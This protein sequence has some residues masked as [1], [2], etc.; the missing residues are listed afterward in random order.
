MDHN[1]TWRKLI[2]GFMHDLVAKRKPAQEDT[3]SRFPSSKPTLE[4]ERETDVR[5]PEVQ[6]RQ[7]SRDHARGARRA[8]RRRRTAARPETRVGAAEC[9]EIADVAPHA[10]VAHV[11]HES[12]ADVAG[13]V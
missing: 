12:T 2:R 1:M 13:A 4:T 8:T 7:Q 9:T 6:A 11:R 10:P 5:A 3:R